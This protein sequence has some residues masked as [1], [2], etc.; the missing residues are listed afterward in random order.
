MVR[1]STSKVR[2]S[3]GDAID[4]VVDSG[5]RI[6]LH[7][8]GKD[9]AALISMQDLEFLRELED[10]IDL[11]EAREALRENGS[12]PWAELKKRLGL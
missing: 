6:V 12:V 1:E 11:E 3:F 5:E 4:R 10:R 9:V 2:E 8:R 7:R